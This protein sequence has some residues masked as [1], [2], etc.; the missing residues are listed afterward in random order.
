MGRFLVAHTL[1]NNSIFPGHFCNLQGVLLN[2]GD[3]AAA[4]WSFVIA[5]HTFLLLA[6]GRKWR[7][8]ISDFS[9]SGKGRWLVSVTVWFTALF[10]ATVGLFLVQNI[11]PERGPF[12]IILR[13]YQLIKSQ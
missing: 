12:C 7:A 13:R 1:V 2:I 9:T 5:T 4:L 3:V 8:W 11:H 6:G 10:I